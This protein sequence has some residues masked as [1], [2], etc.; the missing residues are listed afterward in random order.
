LRTFAAREREIR[1]AGLDVVALSVDGAAGADAGAPATSPPDVQQMLE[2]LKF[3]FR[4]G[5]ADDRVLG[6]LQTLY[7]IPFEMHRPMP[8]PTSFLLDRAGRVAAIY[9]GPVE[10]K[11][12]LDDVAKLSLEGEALRTAALPFPGRWH[13]P[14][15]APPVLRVALDLLTKG[16]VDD[17]QRYVSSNRPS[18]ERDREFPKLLVWLG[19]ERIKRGDGRPGVEHYAD[20]LRTDPSNL[21]AMNNLAWQLA[22]HADASVRNGA[23]AV[24]WAEKAAAATGSKDPRVLDTLAAAY[25]EAGRFDEAATAAQRAATVARDAGQKDLESQALANLKRY[26]QRLKYAPPPAGGRR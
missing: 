26:Q 24:R 21:L 22:T 16:D 23:E 18:L 12:L 2:Q 3:P 4:R 10:V 20:A 5:M 14:P 13:T 15:A 6:R 11:R 8:V 17:A 19:D 7:D 1:A 9:R 25:A